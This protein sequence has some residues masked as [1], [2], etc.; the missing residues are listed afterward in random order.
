M[1]IGGRVN[2]RWLQAHDL[3]LLPDFSRVM[4]R[5]RYRW[6]R[7]P[8]LDPISALPACSGDVFG[9]GGCEPPQPI[10][11]PISSAHLVRCSILQKKCEL[12]S[13]LSSLLELSGW[14][15]ARVVR[16]CLIEDSLFEPKNSL[17]HS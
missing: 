1:G 17:F 9:I 8:E 2:S 5:V 12:K 14:R 16:C 13:G 11:R 4:E 3:D 7:A 6:L 10:F 15:E